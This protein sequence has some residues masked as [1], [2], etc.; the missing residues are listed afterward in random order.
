MLLRLLTVAVTAL[1]VSTQTQAS[2]HID[3]VGSLGAH[4]QVDISDLYAYFGER[5][6]TAAADLAA[7]LRDRPLTLV[8]NTY[9]GAEMGSH[10]SHHVA[11][12][13]LLS[14]GQIDERGILRISDVPA[15]VIRCS[16]EDHVT[17]VAT[18]CA[19]V[20]GG[21]IGATVSA[22]ADAIAESDGIRLFSG[23][24]ADPFF[25]SLEHFV[26]VTGRPDA[27]PPPVAPYSDDNPFGGNSFEGINVI[28]I[29]L[30]IDWNVL[31]IEADLVGVAARSVYGHG[32]APEQFD[33]FG[34]PE[35]TNLTLHDHSGSAE[36]RRAYNTGA[37]L[38]D[39]YK[40]R[41]RENIAAYDM[42][43]GK[44]DWQPALLDR[45]VEMLLEDY[46]VL[47]RAAPCEGGSTYLS[48]ERAL[49][50]GDAPLG[51]GARA[52]EEDIFRRMY[53]LFIAG[54]DGDEA[55][56]GMGVDG[57]YS[58]SEKTLSP[59]FPYLAEA[60]EEQWPHWLEFYRAGKRRQAID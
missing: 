52:L 46:T 5:D 16:F 49:L 25:Y 44:Q 57:P 3:N 36:L 50:G 21:E 45:F 14:P 23:L 33:Y 26:E 12:E 22:P 9:P 38:E 56:F 60:W 15:A 35:I 30:E 8:V 20:R 13:I 32:D 48:I 10:F 27:F 19:V 4:G 39:A 59:A 24:R 34:R 11:Y 37:A 58:S 42:I 40:I 54:L 28:S 41:L 1:A 55:R 47:N 29:V 2:D 18:T 17:P 43:D 6:C 7:C 53:T 31:G 51:C